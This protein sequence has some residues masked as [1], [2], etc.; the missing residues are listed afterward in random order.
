MDWSE[1]SNNS[2][3]EAGQKPVRNSLSVTKLVRLVSRDSKIDSVEAILFWFKWVVFKTLVI[4][5]TI[6]KV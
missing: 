6:L 5:Y 2:K 3:V 1:F 4:H